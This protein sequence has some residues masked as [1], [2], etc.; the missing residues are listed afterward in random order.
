MRPLTIVL[1]D[2]AMMKPGLVLQKGTDYWRIEQMSRESRKIRHEG[3][4]EFRHYEEPVYSWHDDSDGKVVVVAALPDGEQVIFAEVGS[5]FVPP[6]R[7]EAQR[8]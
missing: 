4:R 6:G 7:Y 5:V 2:L 1:M 3:R 8:T